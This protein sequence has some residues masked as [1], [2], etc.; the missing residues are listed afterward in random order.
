LIRVALVARTPLARAGLR[1][2]LESDP[3]LVV[4]DEAADPYDIAAID[5]DGM[6]VVLLDGQSLIASDLPPDVTDALPGLVLLGGGPELE[7]ELLSRGCPVGRLSREATGDQIRAAIVAVAAGLVALEPNPGEGLP[8]QRRSDTDT[9]PPTLTQRERDV[10]EL[11]AA[12]LTNKGIA[13]RL[14]ISEHTV[15][16]HLASVL[17]KLDAGS[18]AEAVARAAR[19]GLIGL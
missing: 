8:I 19:R 9:N 4:V 3:R 14:G 18:R 7:R 10:L 16:F 11:V 13:L 17:T 12:G 5:W 1:A 15:K 6:D 2:L